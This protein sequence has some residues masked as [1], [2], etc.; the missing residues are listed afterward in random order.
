MAAESEPARG[1][2]LIYHIDPGISGP[3]GERSNHLSRLAAMGFDTVY[4]AP[5]RSDEANGIVAAARQCGLAV[6][7]DL[8]LDATTPAAVG[9]TLGTIIRPL[10]E[11]GVLGF[12]CVAAHRLPPDIW[13]ALIR[14]VRA[15]APRAFFSADTLGA[16]IDAAIRLRGVGFDFIFNSVAW[17]DWHSAWFIE[18]HD[19]QRRI[20][21]TIGFPLPPHG[22]AVRWAT[23]GRNEPAEI[24]AR[25]R[26]LY[27]L[28]AFC[29]SG[30]IVPMGY[31]AG[32]APGAPAEPL[33][34]LAD[35]ITAFNAARR[36]C[37]ALL[38]DGPLQL[39]SPADDPVVAMARSSN[40]E[41][42]WAFVLLNRDADTARGVVTDTLLAAAGECPLA[43]VATGPDGQTPIAAPEIALEPMAARLLTG[44]TGPAPT[45]ADRP[46]PAGLHHPSWRADARIAIGDVSPVIDAGRFPVKRIVGDRVEIT[47]DILR[48][49]HDKLAAIVKY[50]RVEE[51][52][53]R[54]TAMHH[55]ENDRWGGSFS[56]DGIGRYLFA[57]E[58]WTDHFVSWRSETEKKRDAGQ[59][60]AV[61]LIEGRALVAAAMTRA[62]SKDQPIFDAILGTVDAAAPEDCTDL[63]MSRL[64][65]NLMARWPDRS[66]VVSSEPELEIVVGR[67]A[68]RF[69][70][71]YEMFPRS[72]GRIPERGASFDDCISRLPDIA[73]L[74]F[75]VVYLVPIHPIGRINRK[76]RDNAVTA[77]PGD[78]GSPYAIGAA[79]GGH[80][81][82]HPEL[83]TIEDFR[84]FVAAAAGHG[85]EVA[86][87]F[88]VQCAPDHPWTRDHPQ[89][90]VFRPD[91]TIKYAENPP[92][93]YQDIVNVDFYNPDREALW[94][95]L[96]DV[97][98]FWAREGVR[99]FRVDNPHTKP[100]PFWEWCIRE[101]QAEYPDTIFLSEAFTRPKIMKL[102]AKAGFTQSYSYFTWRNTKHELTEY[103]TELTQ[104]PERECMQ[105][106]FFTNTPD[107]LPKILQDGGRPAFRM[108]FVLAATLSPAYG[109]YNG[110]ELCEN[111]AI[112]GTEEYLH[113]E[114]Y[115]YKVWDWDRPGNI[116][117]EIATLNR[118]RRDN[119]ALRLFTN[120]VFCDTDDEHVLAYLKQTPDR[121]NIVLVVLNLDPFA[122]HEALV[123]LPLH[124]LGVA[125]D[126]RFHLDEALSG[127]TYD[128]RGAHHRFRLDPQLHPALVFRLVRH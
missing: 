13:R 87:D 113:S 105:P 93:K 85:M 30:L 61:E 16:P 66:D 63:L 60:I 50:R 32:W 3:L 43:L 127:V 123:T 46:P 110:F 121:G 122:P 15:E 82:V 37:P 68:A 23:V 91:G 52:A 84:R 101:V 6:M 114:K 108:R 109:I 26:Q 38:T 18:Q 4:I 22:E 9:E 10:L 74:G 7:V 64:V 117:A 75:D 54:W 120:L 20:A 21:P 80:C 55:V 12:R 124:D 27:A 118:F 41:R 106:N 125:P 100:V 14:A 39:L 58:A 102:L 44:D 49:G 47:A 107:I 119:P 2:P 94:R 111:T 62:G 99:I 95:E 31:E 25:Y 48:D 78:P 8:A 88:A 29:S 1:A 97:F 51:A 53:W 24:A 116:K 115:E 83:G 103:L 70:A 112:P 33:F 86:L 77:A 81:A 98:L 56:A 19:M 126:D 17:W 67:E 57:V 72:Q 79:E 104:G 69:A 89:W 90:F 5:F 92:K 34:D 28:A 96:R 45:G 59:D 36:E 42:S 76:G 11:S 71:W 65:G 128:G 35:F 40:D 73:E